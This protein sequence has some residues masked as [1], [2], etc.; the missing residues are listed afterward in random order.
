MTTQIHDS[1]TCTAG[2]R[3]QPCLMCHFAREFEKSRAK[4]PSDAS[5]RENQGAGFPVPEAK[6]VSEGEY[7][8]GM[9][10]CRDCQ[11]EGRNCP[12]CHGLGRVE[13]YEA[14]QLRLKQSPSTAIPAP[15]FDHEWNSAPRSM[16]NYVEREIAQYFYL[17]GLRA[18]MR[19]EFENTNQTLRSLIGKLS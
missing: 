10:L 19:V 11:G 13:T 7:G 15:D 4:L 14:R 1:T 3:G 8:A 18:G 2:F 17:C 9:T 12:Y 16:K 6:N 5:G